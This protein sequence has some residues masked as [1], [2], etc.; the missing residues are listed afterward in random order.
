V[1]PAIDD[2]SASSSTHTNGSEVDSSQIHWNE[3]TIVA[4]LTSLI[5]GFMFLMM[6]KVRE[7]SG[8]ANYCLSRFKVV[9]I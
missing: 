9:F 1:T 8:Y 6:F 2:T 3:I 4:V 7:I 5:T